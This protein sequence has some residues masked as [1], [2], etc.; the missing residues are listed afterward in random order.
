MSCET[1]QGRFDFP[2]CWEGGS[3][4][5][6]DISIAIENS[7]TLAAA[8]IVFK[9]AGSDTASLT[10]NDTSGL[11]LTDTT[12]GA[13]VVTVE[14]IDTIALTAGT[15]YY[16]MKLTESGGAKHHPL[17]GTWPIKNT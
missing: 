6:F 14:Q 5:S 17:A 13:Y 1:E 3:L 10:I 9:A 15:Y 8:E 11:T 7:G 2:T 16:T 12:A 4:L